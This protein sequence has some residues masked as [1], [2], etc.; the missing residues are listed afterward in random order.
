M[1]TR[2]RNCAECKVIWDEIRTYQTMNVLVDL[3]DGY[4]QAAQ[5]NTHVR[6]N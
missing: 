4:I 1:V 6:V 3:R 2:S 5:C